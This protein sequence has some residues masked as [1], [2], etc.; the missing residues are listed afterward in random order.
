[1]LRALTWIVAI[2][3][4]AVG[5]TLLAR[6]STGYALFVW[7]PYRIELSLNFLLLLIAAAFVALYIVV[8]MVSA[9]ARLPAQVREYRAARRRR[10]ARATF[11]GALHEYLSGRYARA[12]KAA[13]RALEMGEHA[14]LAALLAA[15]AAQ[16]LRAYDRRDD[17]LAR[18]AAA[19]GS[20]EAT[21]LVT[22]AELF[23][24]QG[25]AREAL[26]VLER[27]PRRHT[28]ALRLEL[29][30][31]Q[32]LGN[33]DKTLALLA[34][35]NRRK[36]FDPEKAADLRRI[37]LVEHLRSRATDLSALEEAWNRVAAKERTDARIAAA[38]VRLFMGLGGC[39]Q[40]HRIIEEALESAWDSDL[41]A[42][43]AECD[44]GDT[45]RRIERAESWLKSYPRDA[46]L[47]LTLGR[48][49]SAQELWG[50]AQSYLEASIAVEPTYSAHFSLAGL[51][52]KLGDAEAAQRHYRQSLT[53]AL[54][55]LDAASGGQRRIPI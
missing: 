49:C 44:G 24:E 38:A 30:A 7:P 42:L 34:E 9:T 27:L 21:R 51:H 55:Q 19:A 1:M 33:W 37:A 14:D 50:K 15:R 10:K 39:T 28:A 26:E 43:Y 3:A 18:A 46:V 17:Y 36:A 53:L 8:R 11:A 47:L 2:V 45:L 20:D 48:L 12:E 54:A 32:Q 41:V 52:E 23:L 25:R 31:H 22:E 6:Y 4:V 29:A 35:L 16:G 13:R 40:A 5:L